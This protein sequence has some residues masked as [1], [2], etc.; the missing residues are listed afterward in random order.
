MNLEQYV[1]ENLTATLEEVQSYPAVEG[2]KLSAD[3]M[4]SF[5]NLPR[6]Q[7]YNYFKSAITSESPTDVGGDMYNIGDLKMTTFDN[8]AGV[9]E[10]NFIA[11]HPSDQ[12]GLMDV[13]IFAETNPTLKK[14][15]SILKVVCLKYCNQLVYPFAEVTKLQL[16][17]TKGIYTEK[18]V[19][20]YA[21]GNSLKI[22]LID[23]LPESCSITSWTKDGLFGYENL[24]KHCHLKTTENI[25]KL[26]LDNKLVEGKLFV[27]VPFANFNYT[28]ELM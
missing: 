21:Q 9:G 7:L 15:L 4:R 1:K 11:G 8:M 18:E 2:K 17:Q 28:V 23:S 14:Q 16:N 26:Q 24:G 10:F 27:R 12:S 3:L 6:V 22:T 20:G 5:L 19:V 25:Y 13:L